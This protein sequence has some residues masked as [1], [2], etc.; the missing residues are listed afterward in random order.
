MKGIR[1]LSI[2]IGP[3]CNLDHEWCPRQRMVRKADP[4]KVWEIVSVIR[5]AVKLGFDG[6]VAFHY[7]N[8]PCLYPERMAAV[9]DA[10]PNQRFMLWTNGTLPIPDGFSTIIRTAYSGVG[11]YPYQP[12]TRLKNYG[13]ELRGSVECVRRR[14]EFPIAY[15]GSVRLC[16]QDWLGSV[17]VGNV[18]SEPLSPIWDKWSRLNLSMLPVCRS[19]T[20]VMPC[21]P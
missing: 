8:E 12:D 21:L 19:C 18:T 13:D 7:Y 4:L 10:L 20:G 16:C 6:E 3:D 5:E 14:I 2:E 15:D 1:Y 11:E 9:M 17:N